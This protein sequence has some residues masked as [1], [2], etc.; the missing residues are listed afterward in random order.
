MKAHTVFFASIIISAIGLISSII[1]RLWLLST[2]F[3]YIDIAIDELSYGVGL[4]S[5]GTLL[6]GILLSNLFA[7]ND[8]EDDYEEV[9][10]FQEIFIR[11]M[12]L[13]MMVAAVF[14]LYSSTSSI[15]VGINEYKSISSGELIEID[16]EIEYTEII[17]IERKGKKRFIQS[18]EFITFDG[19]RHTF[20]TKVKG[21][22]DFKL[23][24]DKFYRVHLSPIKCSYMGA[25]ELNFE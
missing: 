12:V 19:E 7:K 6:S 22:S 21:E 18:I 24:E 14:L 4:F 11:L 1:V 15:S 25:W 20:S 10:I 5:L 17:K 3:S 9:S 8:V 16:G 13:L 23:T 2:E